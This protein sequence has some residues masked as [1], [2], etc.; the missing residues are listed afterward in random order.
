MTPEA[1]VTE[2]FNSGVLALLWVLGLVGGIGAG[3]VLDRYFGR[4]AF[5]QSRA[6][7][8]LGLIAALAFIFAAIRLMAPMT[9]ATAIITFVAC[10][11]VSFWHQQVQNRRT[12]NKAKTLA[13]KPVKMKLEVKPDENMTVVVVYTAKDGSFK[14]KEIFSADV[15]KGKKYAWEIEIPSVSGTATIYLV[16]GDEGQWAGEKDFEF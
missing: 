3:M 10:A 1:M 12:A 16:T 4:S 7:E 15:E 8:G 5:F 6:S 11:I 9:P 13:P 14:N 2:S